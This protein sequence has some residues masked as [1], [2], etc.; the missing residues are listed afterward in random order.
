MSSDNLK[1]KATSAMIWTAMEK[2][3]TMI[4]GFISGI[5]LARLLTP[6]DYGCIGM[7]AIFM[8]LANT[9]IDGGF[10]SALIQKKMPTQLD[11]STIFWWNMAMSGVLY[12]VLFI[13]AP[14]I[15]DFYSIP[16]L[17]PVLR[18]QALVLFVNALNL[19]Q[20]NQL[21]KKLNFK[22]LSQITVITSIIA[23]TITIVMAY[24]GFGVWALVA[25]YLVSSIIPAFIYWG[26]VRWRPQFVF[27][28]KSFRELFSFGGYLFLTNIVGTF[29]LRMQGLLVGKFY[30]PIVLGYY[31]K[32]VSTESL[33]SQSISSIMTQVT[34]PLYAQVQDDLQALRN[35]VKRLTMTISYVTFPL[36][37]I[38]ILIA[39]PLF[40]LLY[41]EKWVQCV[42]YFQILCFA[43]IAVSLQSI[44]LQTISAIGK[45]K[46][47]FIWT[48]VKSCFRLAFVCIGLVFWGINGLLW[49]MVLANWF[50]LFVNMS[51][52]SKYIGYSLCKQ[53]TDISPVV[54]VSIT[55]LSISY[56]VG[57]MLQLGIYE[58]GIVKACLFLLIYCT[59][60]LLFK[61]EAFTYAMSS[62]QSKLFHGKK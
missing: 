59:W 53:V 40:I 21:R 62:I 38:L 18:V 35:I 56:F 31:S 48:I 29:T 9:M 58:D 50:V 34:Y 32:A 54:L 6:H 11:Y 44:N 13:S 49:G 2:Y 46:Q 47:M 22:L 41:S 60:S 4:I 42:P 16:L 55:A 57:N 24:K 52:V 43:G 5:I 14:Y 33:A 27:S 7:L 51:L 19:I 26:Y 1:K 28:W 61:P 37:F 30:N 3:A 20:S 36:L 17:S 23:L 15:A 45:S 12:L 39:K 25:Q 10:G 8:A